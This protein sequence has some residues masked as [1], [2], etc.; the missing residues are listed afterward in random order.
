M[1]CK[2]SGEGWGPR[3]SHAHN[4]PVVPIPSGQP[5]PLYPQARRTVGHPAVDHDCGVL[6]T[7]HQTM[8]ILPSHENISKSRQNVDFC[9]CSS[10]KP[11]SLHHSTANN[12]TPRKTTRLLLKDTVR[13]IHSFG[14]RTRAGT[15]ATTAN[16][17]ADASELHS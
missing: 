14:C 5:A 1:A 12:M 10:I 17:T 15:K 7:R 16:A 11:R 8:V 9:F 6:R 13:G 4:I 3:S 2:S